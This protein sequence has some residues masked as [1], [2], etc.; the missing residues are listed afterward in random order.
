MIYKI[1]KENESSAT[2]KI[3]DLATCFSCKPTS[4]RI[5]YHIF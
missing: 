1:E 3:N 4:N 2:S 5:I